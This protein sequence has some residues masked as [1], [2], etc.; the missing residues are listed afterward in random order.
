MLVT[1]DRPAP[2][3][4]ATSIFDYGNVIILS[5]ENHLTAPYWI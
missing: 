2:R 1:L 4:S 3:F 5:D